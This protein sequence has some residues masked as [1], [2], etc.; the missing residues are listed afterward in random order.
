MK[1]RFDRVTKSYGSRKI[2]DELT[3][4][5]PAGQ[6][7]ILLGASGAGKSQILKHLVGLIRPDSG[8]IYLDD[9]DISKFSESKLSKYRQRFGFIFQNGGLLESLSVAENVGLPLMEHGT[10]SKK[11]CQALVSE[12]LKM[13]GLE[14]REDQTPST[15]SGGQRKRVAIARA[16]VCNVEAFLFDEPTAGLDP[17]TAETID[18]VIIQV[19]EETNATTIVVTHDLISV[20]EVAERVLLL[21]E[22]KIYFDGT[23][24]EFRNS[25]D[26]KVIEFLNREM[27]KGFIKAT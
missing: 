15:L 17:M 8:S 21:S 7:C 26:D 22:G 5:V 9:E 6:R 20:A 13:V 23:P 10:H 18:D 24:E 16:L 14:G 27:E 3:F 12:K 1:L 4:E 25:K 19:N 11:E 2:F